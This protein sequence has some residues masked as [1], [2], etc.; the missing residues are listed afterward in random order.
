[1]KGVYNRKTMTDHSQ[2]WQD[3]INADS[4]GKRNLQI[5]IILRRLDSHKKDDILGWAEKVQRHDSNLQL[6]PTI[7]KTKLF[8]MLNEWTFTRSAMYLKIN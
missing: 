2:Q 7:I 8:F 4:T 5:G 1:M 6:F 3:S